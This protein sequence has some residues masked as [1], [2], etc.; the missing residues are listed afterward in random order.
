MKIRGELELP[1]ELDFWNHLDSFIDDQ[2]TNDFEK[3]SK[4]EEWYDYEYND[5]PYSLNIWL[6]EDT[7][8]GM[9]PDGWRV[10]ATLYRDYV[11]EHGYLWTD[12]NTYAGVEV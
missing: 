9:Y 1:E 5:I 4:D 8:G 3:T 11:D 2:L 6:E 10:N 12:T 7:N